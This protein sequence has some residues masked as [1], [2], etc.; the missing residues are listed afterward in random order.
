MAQANDFLME[1]RLRELNPELHK[2]FTNALFALQFT[3]SHYKRLFPEYTDHTE[4]HSMNVIDFC[5]QLIGA[6]QIDLLNVD[7]LYVLLMSCYLHDVGMGVSETDYELFMP[8]L[9]GNE[10]LAKNPTRGI[11][12]CIREYHHELSGA[13]IKKYADFLD[14]PSPEHVFCIVQVSRGH[15]R[16]NLLDT[17]EYP[18][19]YRV[20]DGNTVCLPYLAALIRLADEIDVAAERN[21]T[22]LYDIELLIGEVEIFHNRLLTV[23]RNLEVTP[24][25]FIM[26]VETE[27]AALYAAIE[28]VRGKMQETLDLCRNVVQARSN[29]CI[30]QQ[31]VDIRRI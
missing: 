5:N 9:G 26:E 12:E 7:E 29:Y 14:I 8:E 4:L 11:S 16:T 13:F 22:L 24:D 30:H 20:P 23:V 28:N 2:R 25:S 17:S 6:E 19:D 3:L 10:Y 1:K 15:R 18:P 21:P 31:R 27:D